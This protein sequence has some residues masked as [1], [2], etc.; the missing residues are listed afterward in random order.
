MSLVIF[1]ACNGDEDP[2][3]SS[4]SESSGSDSSSSSSEIPSE[5]ESSSSEPTHECVFGDWQTIREPSFEEAGLR[6]R[7]C[8][9]DGCDKSESEDIPKLVASFYITIEDGN[10]TIQ[11]PLLSDGAY[12]LPTPKG[13]AGY[14]FV[15]YKTES[16]DE[17][18]TSGTVSANVKIIAEYQLLETT[19]FAQLKER[20]EAGADLIY[21]KADI[22]LTDTIYVVDK[23]T[24]Y[25]DESHTLTRATDFLG[26]LFILGCDSKGFNVTLIHKRAELSIKPEGE[27]VITID[28]NKGAITQDVSGTAFFIKNSSI[29]NI[30]DNVKLINL[31]KTANS[32]LLI[33]DHNM[34]GPTQVGGPVAIIA[35]GSFNMYGG[36]ISGCEADMD[37][38]A[39]T[40]SSNQVDGYDSSS[41]GGAIFNYSTFNM[42]GGKIE[43]CKAGRGGAIYNYRVMNLVAGEITGCYTPSYGGVVYQP[44]SQYTYSVIGDE[45]GD[46]EQ[47]LISS[48]SAGKSGGAFYIAHLSVAYVK[49]TAKFYQNSTDSNG[50]AINCAGSLVVDGATFEG[51]TA[52]SKGGAIYAYYDKAEYTRRIIEL[53]SG[54]F[55]DNEAPRGGAIALGAG[56]SVSK[57]AHARLGN[58]SLLTNN[59]PLN[60]SDK[61]GYGGAIH[62][63]SA[64]TL[65]IY[66]STRLESNTS[67]NN[68]GAI[69]VTKESTVNIIAD[70]GINI[71]F[72]KNTAGANGGAIY[73]SSSQITIKRLDGGKIEFT[74]NEATSS[75][76]VFA[77]HSQGTNYLYGIYASGNSAGKDGGVLYVYGSQAVVGDAQNTTKSV[78]EK[79]SATRGGAVY[80]STTESETSSKSVDVDIYELELLENSSTDSGGA[81]C[82]K[83]YADATNSP[84][85]KLDIHKLVANQ[86]TSSGNGGA[87]HIYTLAEVKIDTLVA[88]GNTA[89]ESYGG[90]MYISG[91]ANCEINS[92]SAT[93]NSASKGG[94]IYLTTGATTLTL[95]GGD[96]NGNTATTSDGGNAL[97]CNSASSVLK[98]KTNENDEYLLSFKSE[99]ILG[100][101]G[102]AITPY[103]EEATA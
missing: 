70:N 62:V 79:N 40:S 94:C 53:N 28:G 81:L 59:A 27:A 36:L 50:G 46:S 60:S 51:N 31:K 84:T 75:G 63:D 14:E 74:S 68:G 4:S 82:A 6:Q 2:S 103:K 77:I 90:V 44:N 89:P 92:I 73:N 56:D 86:N 52:S 7:F 41:R 87:L 1:N 64:S 16:G 93:S 22:T 19:T 95:N 101:S 69:Y 58:V 42:Y 5:S 30:Y 39:V 35:N 15:A 3:S 18:A 67:A 102:F 23:T 11:L 8:Q 85:C 88:N 21:L 29:L 91:K 24:I 47:M 34:S 96:I 26:D 12:T 20:I 65:E 54:V 99:D 49:E 100:K 32:Y 71:L 9:T 57:G 33:D 45:S 17:F 72:D 48:N 43:N 55:K 61:Y 13:K 83:V 37:D 10:S 38:S 66:G 78:F 80:I 76:G 98:I 25:S 97:W